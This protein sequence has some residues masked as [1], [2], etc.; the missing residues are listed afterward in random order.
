MSLGKKTNST[1]SCSSVTSAVFFN[2]KTKATKQNS[3]QPQMA[4]TIQRINQNLKEIHREIEMM[5]SAGKRALANQNW[6]FRFTSYWM[7]KWRDFPSALWFNS[8]F[9]SSSRLSPLVHEFSYSQYLSGRT[10][11]GWIKRS[12]YVEIKSKGPL[13]QWSLLLSNCLKLENLL[14]WSF[15]TL[16]YN[17]SSNIWIISYI[18]HIIS[19]ITGDMN[20]INWPRSQCVA[21]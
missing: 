4:E 2:R 17:R 8:W 19:L 20:S 13:L 15:F 16:I 1:I 10:F 21:S 11:F 3:S 9:G 12:P 7:K 5:P 18:L 6:F 14:W